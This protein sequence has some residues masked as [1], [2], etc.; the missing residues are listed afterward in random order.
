[1]L[2]CRQYAGENIGAFC[3]AVTSSTGWQWHSYCVRLLGSCRVQVV[4]QFIGYRT[5]LWARAAYVL[6]VCVTGGAAWFVGHAFPRAVLWT[7]EECR[8]A[9]ADLVLAKVLL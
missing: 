7:L 2:S 9:D 3:K 6:L 8:L 1:M 4:Q 5:R